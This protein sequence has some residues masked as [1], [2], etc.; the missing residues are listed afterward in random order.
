MQT[1]RARQHAKRPCQRSTDAGRNDPPA[2]G[3]Q[4]CPAVQTV[5]LGGAQQC[6]FHRSRQHHG[7]EGS[8]PPHEALVTQT[9]TIAATVK[10]T[11]SPSVTMITHRITRLER[12]DG[13]SESDVYTL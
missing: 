2:S 12:P 4:C 9:P 6:S 13:R 5:S 8:Q 10:P 11:A 1:N 7:D 3:W